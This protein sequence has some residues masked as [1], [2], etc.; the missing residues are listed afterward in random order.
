MLQMGHY[1]KWM[2]YNSVSVRLLLAEFTL[3]ERYFIA[4]ILKFRGGQLVGRE[5]WITV[6]L[7]DK[8]IGRQ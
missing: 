4:Y 2:L 7:E 1:S 5:M 6:L 3:S 8:E